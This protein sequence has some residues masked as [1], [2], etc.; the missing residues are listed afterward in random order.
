MKAN[1]VV[2][3]LD[4]RTETRSV[5]GL[6]TDMSYNPLTSISMISDLPPD[7]IGQLHMFLESGLTDQGRPGETKSG[8][9]VT[10]G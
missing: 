8:Q 2:R 5:V 9:V 3:S 10:V 1:M 6:I 7:R 4:D